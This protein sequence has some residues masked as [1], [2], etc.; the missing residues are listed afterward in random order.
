[1]I[2]MTDILSPTFHETVNID[3]H[4]KRLLYMDLGIKVFRNYELFK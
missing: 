4:V 1:M 2:E 3:A